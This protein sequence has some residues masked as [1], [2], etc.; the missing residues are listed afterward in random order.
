VFADLGYTRQRG[1]TSSDGFS[2]RVIVAFQPQQDVLLTAQV[3]RGFRLGGI[4]DP[5]NV[6]LCAPPDLIT[7]GG[8]PTFKDEKVLNYELGAKTQ[9]AGGRVTF[10]A[11]IFYSDI[12]DLQVIADA[13]S[14]SSR[15]V[16]N[17]QAQSV[18]G[19]VELQAR[20]NSNWDLGLSATYQQAEITETRTD[21][22]G[23]PIAGIRDGNRLPTSPEFQASASVTYNWPFTPSMD[24]FV[25]FT[26]QYVG[27][28]YTQLA[29]QEAPF[30]VVDSNPATP[31]PGFFAFGNPTISGF[32]FNPELPSY[33]IGNLRFGVRTTAWEAA[34]FV[35]NVWDERARL[36]LDRE[37]GSRGRVGFLTNTPR[38]YGAMLRMNF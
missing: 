21:A 27:S 15:I 20:P 2:P 11:A 32:T 35:N 34:A 23:T 10:N 9:L 36:S 26:A 8:Q 5:L 18:G 12:D 14:C 25:N 6:P 29:D 24:G 16:L 33:D 3:S 38:T 7:Y 30:G 13:G 4:N 17:A 19:E 37:R 1:S 22:T 31:A 28:S